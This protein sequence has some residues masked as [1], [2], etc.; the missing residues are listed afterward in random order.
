[1]EITIFDGKVM[2]GEQLA[3][4]W[5]RKFGTIESTTRA[6]GSVVVE[7]SDEDARDLIE[8]LDRL[9]MNYEA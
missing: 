1:M 7:I 8:E 6:T 2:T 9:G 5:S 3:K 4:L